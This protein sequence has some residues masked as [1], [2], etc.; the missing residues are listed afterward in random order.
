MKSP[1]L[2]DGYGYEKEENVNS[3]KK[4]KQVTPKQPFNKNKQGGK[5]PLDQEFNKIKSEPKHTH[6]EADGDDSTEHI[7]LK[8][9]EKRPRLS[10]PRPSPFGK[11]PFR[12]GNS[13][14][15]SQQS[16]G[17]GKQSWSKGNGKQPGAEKAAWK[18]KKQPFN[19]P[20][21][22]I[23]TK[24]IESIVAIHKKRRNEMENCALVV[25]HG[26]LDVE[27]WKTLHPDI[28][29]ARA[30]KKNKMV[31]LNFPSE[32]ARNKAYKTI[33]SN[34]TKKDQMVVD[35]CGEKSKNLKRNPEDDIDAAALNPKMLRLFGV[36]YNATME[37]LLT[38]FPK[39]ACIKIKTDFIKNPPTVL[40]EYVRDTAAHEAFLQ[41][42]NLK[43]QGAQIFVFYALLHGSANANDMD[44]HESLGQ[45]EVS[46]AKQEVPAK[47]KKAKESQSITKGGKSKTS[48]QK[49]S[50]AKEELKEDSE[51]ASDDEDDE[52]EEEES[53]SDD[54]V[55][56][57]NILDD[58][59][60][61]SDEAI[62]QEGGQDDSDSGSSEESDDE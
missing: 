18:K 38:L 3:A 53:D 55:A 21:D 30:S 37:D 44:D 60:S 48:A 61:S 31:W 13:D 54:E 15:Q 24:E 47:E 34:K 14:H 17:P 2:L 49:L 56:A 42:D 23:M 57:K 40:V 59:G 20:S 50:F 45:E 22:T 16:F 58:S 26:G 19:K 27:G 1:G 33:S 8:P 51:D 32:S 9:V 36:P 11:K 25:K 41:A 4:K 29:T 12:A 35:Y 39:A 7:S 6:F 52:E 62:K 10:A 43:M 28:V 5:R 46:K